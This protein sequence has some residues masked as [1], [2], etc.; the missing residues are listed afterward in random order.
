[1]NYCHLVVKWGYFLGMSLPETLILVVINMEMQ[2]SFSYTVGSFLY[3]T[4]GL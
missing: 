1:M 4:K 3:V 2:L